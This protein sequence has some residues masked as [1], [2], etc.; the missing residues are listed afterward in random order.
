MKILIYTV[1]P[2]SPHPETDLEL[3]LQFRSRGD[4]VV[5]LRCTGQ[6]TTCL[7]NPR[8][9]AVICAAC[10]SKYL[11][12]LKLA[13]LETIPQLTLPEGDLSK[14]GI[15]D[16]FKDIDA[17]RAFTI[18][19]LDAGNAVT[20]TLVG[21]LNRDHKFNTQKYKTEISKELRTWL[22]VY[23]GFAKVLDSVQPDAVY[24]FNGRFSMYHPAKHLC[25]NRKITWY[26][27][28]R[29][30]LVNKYLIR[31]NALPHN[32]AY[33][34]EELNSLWDN[35]GS[36][37]EELGAKFFTDRRKGVVQS[38][39]SFIDSQK[40]GLLPA[41]FDPANKNI[42]IFNST[43]EEFEG[44]EEWANPLYEDEN[45]G[46]ER[47]LESFKNEPK[48]QFY[49][50]VHPNLKLLNNTQIRNIYALGARYSNLHIIAPEELCDS[51]ALMEFADK[52]VV[53]G[54]T[55]GVEATYWG[56]PSILLGKATYM[57]LDACYQPASHEEAVALLRT[58]GLPPKDKRNAM[59]YGHWELTKGE[60]YSKF[61]QTDLFTMT[62]DGQKI[63]PSMALLVLEKFSRLRLIRNRRDL[64]NI[65]RKLTGM[66]KL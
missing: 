12:A 65:R 17:L 64:D 4:E 60:F 45:E 34:F 35:G 29:G 52:I 46:I 30:G 42:A 55:I 22:Q 7:A 31:K 28:E 26:T 47:L 54:S 2:Q 8:H 57:D 19:G 24:F 59:K 39:V 11:M 13:G 1:Y 38:W 56:K 37:R 14:Y 21:K 51:Y 53:F 25:I 66:L 23:E 50:R 43:I 32:I 61:R 15:P 3:A 6:L 27:H 18:D 33:T 40:R 49:L 58:D 41:G 20:A 10:R 63:R 16:E 9:S 36:G 44:M 48:Y 5:L 62:Y